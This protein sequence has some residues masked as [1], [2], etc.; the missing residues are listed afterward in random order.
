MRLIDLIGG[1]N[2]IPVSRALC[3]AIGPA[4]AILYCELVDQYRFWSRCGKLDDDDMFFSTVKQIQTRTGLSKDQQPRYLRKLAELGLIKTERK[5]IPAKRYIKVYDNPQFLQDLLIVNR[6]KARDNQKSQNAITRNRKIQ[7]QE[8]GKCNDYIINLNTKEEEE[9]R[10]KITAE[11]KVNFQRQNSCQQN[12]SSTEDPI[13]K[14]VEEK[15]NSDQPGIG[16]EFAEDLSCSNSAVSI[17]S[18]YEEPPSLYKGEMRPSL[19]DCSENVVEMV[20]KKLNINRTLAFLVAARCRDKGLL[21]KVIDQLINAKKPI[22]NMTAYLLT[23]M[24][25]P[26]QWELFIENVENEFLT[27]ERPKKP[28]KKRREKKPLE[29]ER[30][31][32]IP[33]SMQ[34]S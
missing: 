15:V 27:K 23:L 19:G 33:P 32:Y 1:S 16:L 28:K 34:K 5:G 30:E 20:M 22:R 26:D 13:E 10:A 8:T 7:R 12:K 3:V 4:E 17:Q 31:I 21:E 9:E 2:Y 18:V 29:E 11:E 6:N 25:R 14:A 24:S